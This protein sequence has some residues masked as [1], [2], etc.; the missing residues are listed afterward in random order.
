MFI[1]VSHSTDKVLKA[2]LDYMCLTDR[3]AKPRENAVSSQ[4]RVKAIL[5]FFM[6]GWQDAGMGG[7]YYTWEFLGQIEH[8]TR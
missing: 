8:L 5:K 4:G 1:S 2:W 7:A 3:R 6:M